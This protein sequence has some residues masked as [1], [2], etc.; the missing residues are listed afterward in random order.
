MTEFQLVNP[1]LEGDG[2][3][4]EGGPDGVLLL[5]GFTATTAEV[6]PLAQFLYGRGYTVAGPLLPGH[7][8]QP[9]DLNRVAWRDWTRAAEEAY[10]GLAARCRRVIIGGE[11]MGGL[12]TL[13]LGSEHP[14]AA[15]L[16]CYAP[17]LLVPVRPFDL[18]KLHLGSWFLLNTSSA[19]GPRT[20]ADDLWQGYPVKPLRG[21][22]Q[23]L[24]LQAEARGRLSGIAHPILIV[25]GRLD[26]T[27][28]PQG[29]Q[30]LHDSVRSAR[31]ELHWMADSTHCV[32]LDQEREPTFALTGAFLERALPGI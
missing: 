1:H 13:Y 20:E 5:H 28:D 8:T 27:I 14:E 31:K 22:R 7:G 11:S 12:L 24:R 4:W 32:I 16:L 29:A 9:A 2:F 30:I 26:R 3:F 10:R 18:L 17:A 23:L 19:P 15:A 21:V 6:R 25:Q